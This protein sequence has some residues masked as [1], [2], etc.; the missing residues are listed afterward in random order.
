MEPD[1]NLDVIVS[2]LTSQKKIDT[3]KN[4][5]LVWN[6]NKNVPGMCGVCRLTVKRNVPKFFTYCSIISNKFFWFFVEI[7]WHFPSVYMGGVNLLADPCSYL[8]VSFVL[9]KG[10]HRTERGEI[11]GSK[12]FSLRLSTF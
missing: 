6:E 8:H 1:T 10:G 2:R 12:I 11:R 9:E 7:K 4:E 5:K 3:K